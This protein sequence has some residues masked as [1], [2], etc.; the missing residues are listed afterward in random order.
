MKGGKYATVIQAK[1]LLQELPGRSE[2]VCQ[3][4][5]ADQRSRRIAKGSG[6]G[7]EAIAECFAAR[8]KI[9]RASGHGEPWDIHAGRTFLQTSFAVD[10]GIEDLLERLGFQRPRIEMAGKDRRRPV[11][12]VVLRP[13]GIQKAGAAPVPALALNNTEP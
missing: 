6:T 1:G 5:K 2:P 8:L 10:A 11:A 3:I 9:M 12:H 4:H 13:R 7:Q